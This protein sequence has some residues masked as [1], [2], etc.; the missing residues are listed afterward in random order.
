M[1]AGNVYWTNQHIN[2]QNGIIPSINVFSKVNISVFS[3]SKEKYLSILC[4][5][6]KEFLEV[7][8]VK[9]ETRLRTTTFLDYYTDFDIERSK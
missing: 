5:V 9:W 6:R 3:Y 8:I 4:K 2:F 7:C 1:N